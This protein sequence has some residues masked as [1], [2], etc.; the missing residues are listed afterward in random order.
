[1]QGKYDKAISTIKSVL[2]SIQEIKDHETEIRS[3]QNIS[4]IYLKLN[5]YKIAEEYADKA[6]FIAD[7]LKDN[8]QYILSLI[9]KINI[10]FQKFN[11]KK[12]VAINQIF[13][14][15]NDRIE[16][17]STKSIVNLIIKRVEALK[18]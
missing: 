4:R 16:Y 14:K 17:T 9:C 7:Y 18:L 13:I 11:F 1:M 2:P 15:M 5:K 10:H 6:I 8:N 3:L 12:I